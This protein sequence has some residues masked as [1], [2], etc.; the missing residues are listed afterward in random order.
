MH[1]RT[2]LV[3]RKFISNTKFYQHYQRHI[4]VVAFRIVNLKLNQQFNMGIFTICE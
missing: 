1:K 2:I 3:S 4:D